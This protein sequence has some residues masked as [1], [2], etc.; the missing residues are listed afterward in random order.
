MASHPLLGAGEG[1]LGH[2]EHTVSADARF[3]SG[4][5]AGSSIPWTSGFFRILNLI[6][7][8][9]LSNPS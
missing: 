8:R 9:S 1:G 5:A 7:P 3:F 6:I 4:G 2:R